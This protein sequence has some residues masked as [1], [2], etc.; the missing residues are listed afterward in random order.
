GAHGA[1]KSGGARRFPSSPPGDPK[2]FPSSPPGDPDREFPT[3][4][5]PA[6]SVPREA[7]HI[8][9]LDADADAVAGR[10]AGAGGSARTAVLWPSR[11]PPAPRS[12]T[13]ALEA[14]VASDGRFEPPPVTLTG[15][16]SLTLA[17]L[18]RLRALLTVASALEPSDERATS[19]RQK[20]ERLLA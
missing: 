13:V 6:R 7:V 11:V 5:R 2:R 16:L 9:W 20:G 4:E 15:D 18:D 12:L 17:P 10:M 3:E 8:L 1:A 19:L 14:A